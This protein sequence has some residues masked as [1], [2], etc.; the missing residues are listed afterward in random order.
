[1]RDDEAT[2]R[3]EPRLEDRQK[4]R[5]YRRIEAAEWLIEDHQIGIAQQERGQ[6]KASRLPPG[7]A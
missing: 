3:F 5:H 4:V 6:L 7:H 2:A 1:M